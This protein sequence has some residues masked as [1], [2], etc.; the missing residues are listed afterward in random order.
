[1]QL[2][3]LQINNHNNHFENNPVNPLIDIPPFFFSFFLTEN[4]KE[5]SADLD[6]QEARF[7]A[8]FLQLLDSAHY[9][10][11]SASEWD[12]A[13]AEEFLLTLPVAVNF[14]AMD[15]TVL[16]RALWSTR[17]AERANAPEEIADRMLI[18]HR[19]VDVAHIQGVYL[20]RKIDLI[21]SFF[22]L[23]PLFALF[24]WIMSLFGVTRFLPEA[25]GY[26]APDKDA[27]EAV[28][29]PGAQAA[30]AAAASDIRSGKRHEATVNIERSTF[31][32]MFPTGGSVLK[33]LFKRIDLKEACFK[34]VVVL[35]RKATPIGAVVPGEFDIIH[36]ADPEFLKRNF[37]VKRF[38]SIPIADLEMVFPDKKVYMPPQVVVQMMVTV[39]GA[40]AAIISALKGVSYT[41]VSQSSH[42]IHIN[43]LVFLLFYT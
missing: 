13:M 16:P 14:N 24:A 17:P 37:I 19:G 5:Y 40:L 1:M 34:D 11:L 12:A 30:A 25:P 36:E 8:G 18:F 31:A 26:M 20:L 4:P 35:Y 41:E 27:K 28:G 23:Q 29:A 43:A 38:A 15:P 7:L 32:R 33:K 10:L 42:S 39:A 22:I 9:K 21:L 2:I 3:K 6:S